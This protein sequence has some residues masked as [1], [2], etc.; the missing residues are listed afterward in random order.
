[1]TAALTGPVSP[2]LRTTLRALK[3]G[4]MLDTLPERLALARQQKMTHAD[5]LELVAA[6]EVTRREA[7]SAGLRA[8]AAG[9]D[10]GMRLD[11][12]DETAAVRYDQQLWNELASLRF[13]DGPHGALILGPVGVGKT[14][15]A[16]AL[17]HIAIRRRR[18]VHMAPAAKLFKRLKAARLDNTLEAEMRRLAGVELLILDDFA[19]QPLDPT[20]TADFYQL[21]VERHRKTATVVTS[22]R[23]PEEWLSMMAD[24]LLAQSAVD[25]LASTAHELIIE[26]QSYRQRQ[27]PSLH[28]ASTGASVDDEKE[29]HHDPS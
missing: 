4:Q 26:G 27:K 18:T 12:R 2:D 17:G 7:K 5:F 22:N 15:M 9:L 25:R 10:A 13:L 1:V 21:C 23:T 24:P 20:E 6:D 3:L 29:D 19:L 8:R 14:H 28:H 11:A 16:S